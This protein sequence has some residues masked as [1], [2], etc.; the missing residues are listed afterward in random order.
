[1]TPQD[2]LALAQKA[3]QEPGDLLKESDIPEELAPLSE[4]I[5]T[6]IKENRNLRK[7]HQVAVD[8][9]RQ[10]INELL[11]IIGTV[12]LRT[13]ELDE[14]HLIA[15]D[16]LG[17]ISQ[18]FIQ[19]LEHLRETNE[20]LSLAMDDIRAI[21][22]SVGGGLLV[23]DSESR[24]LS[25]NK[26]LMEMFVKDEDQDEIIGKKCREIICV[27]NYL[28]EQCSFKQL[29]ET[30]EAVFFTDW[31]Y[32]NNH[33]NI[34]ATPIKD[35]QGNVL[36]SV[37][38]Y[39]DITELIDARSALSAEK[40]RLSFTL[41]SIAEGVVAT[42][43]HSRITLMNRVAE[44]LT[45]W[46]MEEA[47]GKKICEVLAVREDGEEQVAC[48]DLLE[49]IYS[50]KATVQRTGNAVLTAREGKERLIYLSAAPIRYQDKS[51]TG[52][53]L[54][55]RDI[56]G[57][58]KLEEEISKEVR[59]ESLGV[60]AGGIA[61]D[62]NNLLTS[63]LG[64]ISL[65][66]TLTSSSSSIYPLLS[67]TEK[68][69]YRAKSLTQQLLTFAKGGAPVTNVTSTIELIK[70][71]AEFSL[72][73]ANVKC[74]YHIPDNLW[75]V[76]VDEGQI[77]EVI[78]NMVINADQAM[79][80][81]GKIE[82]V[83]E[84]VEPDRLKN[85]PLPPGK[86]VRISIFDHGRGIPP[87]TLKNIFDPYFTTKKAGSGLGLAIC[88]SII[89]KHHGLITVD[90]SLGKGTT[91]HIYL[92]ATAKKL[93]NKSQQKVDGANRNGKILVMDDEELIRDIT[94]TMFKV[95]GY[96]VELAEDGQ[97]AIEKYTAAMEKGEPFDV[98]LMDLT[99]PGG[100]GGKETIEKLL[101]IDP[102]VQAVV[103]S[104]YATD[105]IMSNYKQYGFCQVI[106]KPYVLEELIGT[107]GEVID[108][109]TN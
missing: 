18:S 13:E 105:P 92:P 21:F 93:L 80:D 56:T 55:L 43:E 46:S 53:I 91:F 103:S 72:R 77:S 6:L 70:E 41:E 88:Y 86:Y 87:E 1:M 58:K 19:I 62:F 109:S 51:V 108:C 50:D 90:S 38:L 101:E 12:P 81:G 102:G 52:A 74:E 54:I 83:A 17:I 40:D 79:P 22:E 7:D 107:I 73:G 76:E 4:F 20:K 57:E 33:Y 2:L 89:K 23:V 67:E 48:K 99:I 96:Q 64:N 27:D 82:I 5:G 35:S 24:I 31:K 49:H 97:E 66:K 28:E 65:A 14:Q 94:S 71:S 11:I 100:M 37:M 26:R 44:K 8:Y 29:M 59:I 42:D 47:L 15:I 85:V 98:V 84:N 61:H 68:S 78:Q 106:P 63:V 3:L 30:R 36:R 25:C 60:L 10:K 45:G 9:I 16:P 69:S 32:N 104:G 95:S 39:M 34:A 75:P